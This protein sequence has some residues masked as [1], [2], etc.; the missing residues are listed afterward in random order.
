MG[1]ELKTDLS[2]A[3]LENKL[4]AS[5]SCFQK[6]EIKMLC[7]KHPCKTGIFYFSALG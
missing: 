7:E 5:I 1:P 6:N 2:Q 4:A 3:P